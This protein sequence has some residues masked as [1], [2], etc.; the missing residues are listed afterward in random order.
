MMPGPSQGRVEAQEEDVKATF[1][2]RNVSVAI[3]LVNVF[4]RTHLE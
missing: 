4:A 2:E 1:Q 3:E